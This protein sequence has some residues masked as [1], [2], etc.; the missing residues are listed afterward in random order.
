M[1]GMEAALV[2]S[3][4]KTVGMKIAAMVIKEF[5][6]VA[7][8]RKDLQELQDHVEEINIW[9]QTVGDKAIRNERSSNWLKELKHATYDAEDLVNEFY[10]EAD[11][12]DLAVGVKNTAAKYL[13]TKPKFAMFEWKTACKVKA[14]KKSFDAIVKQRSD[15]SIIANSMPVDHPVPYTGKTIGEVPLWTLVDETSIHGRDQDKNEMISELTRTNSQQRIKIVSVVGLGGSGKT[16]LAK[17]V[18]N[19]D[20]IIK[21]HFEVV[22]WV[23]VS[24]EFFAEKLVEKLF[25]SI[26]GDRADQ[27]PLQHVSRTISD[28]LSGKRFLVILDDVWTEDRVDWE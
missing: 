11:K 9:L 28:K 8:V 16:T 22:L 19:D 15:Y 4:L 14:I 25:E 7:G 23:H 3:M 10:I 12:H 21:K 24:R 1:G 6:S 17:Q 27:L 20:N 5:S 26:G 18:F 2:C 13:W